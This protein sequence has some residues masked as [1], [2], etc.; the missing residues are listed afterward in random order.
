MGIENQGIQVERIGALESSDATRW[1]IKWYAAMVV[2]SEL[3]VARLEG[4]EGN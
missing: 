3:G 1:R 4:I 2:L